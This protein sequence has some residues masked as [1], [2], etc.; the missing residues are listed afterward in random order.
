ML[1]SRAP[2]AGCEQGLGQSR[3]SLLARGEHSALGMAQMLEI[4]LPQQFPD[5][6]AQR[7]DAVQQPEEPQ[8]LADGQVA[9]QRRVHRGKIG[10]RQGPRP[11][12]RYINPVDFYLARGRRQHAQY[13]VDGRRLAGAVG[14]QQ[15]DD[16]AAIHG[17]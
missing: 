1:R 7:G 16:F 13:H 9:R 14:S 10:A 5:A 11:L 12:F 4:E 3:P 2:A 6:V 15:P 8:I 17:K